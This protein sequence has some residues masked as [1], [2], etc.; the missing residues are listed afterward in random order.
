MNTVKH[1]MT[2]TSVAFLLIISAS[3][4][5]LS[6]CG[7]SPEKLCIEE[8]SSLWNAKA[9]SKADNKAYWDAVKVCNENF[10]E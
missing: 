4:L 7:P 3:I 8:Q 9:T 10:K 2:G 6:G 1:L 5:L